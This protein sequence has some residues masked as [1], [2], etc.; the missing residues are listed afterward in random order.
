MAAF[1]EQKAEA[2]AEAGSVEIAGCWCG[3]AAAEGIRAGSAEEER[4]SSWVRCSWRWP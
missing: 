1:L 4:Q 2:D 3:A